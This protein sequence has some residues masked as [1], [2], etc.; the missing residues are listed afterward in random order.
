M[1]YPNKKYKYKMLCD[2]VEYER[3]HCLIATGGII[4][5]HNQ[6][7]GHETPQTLHEVSMLDVYCGEMKATFTVDDT[8]NDSIEP[9]AVPEF[10][11]HDPIKLN[12][13]FWHSK[14]LDNIN[15]SFNSNYVTK[16]LSPKMPNSK[17]S[18]PY[19]FSASTDRKIRYWSVVKG[20]RFDCYNV[21]TPTDNE[22]RYH[23]FYMGD[24]QCIQE[25]V[26]ENTIDTVKLNTT[27]S[28]AKKRKAALSTKSAIEPINAINETLY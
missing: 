12:K 15:D 5:P 11:A 10:Y 9:A 28:Y 23:N 3:E 24:V 4:A 1:Y 2:N 18:V 25:K 17:E 6:R 20:D 13:T 16:V 14:F 22:C 19:F 8:M 27:V 26:Y 21:S 7:T